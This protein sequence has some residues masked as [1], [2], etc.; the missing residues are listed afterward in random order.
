LPLNVVCSQRK[1][2]GYSGGSQ[3][4]SSIEGSLRILL[5]TAVLALLAAYSILSFPSRKDT[6]D[7]SQFYAAGEMVRHG[8]G[9]DLYE[10]NTQLQIQSRLARVHTFY[11][12][13]PFEAI[14]FV[15]FTF[16]SYRT[17]YA[18]WTLLGLGLLI[19]SAWLIDSHAHV[20]ATLSQYLRFPADLG[21]VL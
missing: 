10:L 13:P 16:V 19:G 7:F 17:A 5:V 1:I 18:F 3:I 12:H 6:L 14:A 21:L 8:L 9:H 2:S 15:P 4:R 20:S 11:S